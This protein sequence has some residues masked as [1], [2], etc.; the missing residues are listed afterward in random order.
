[1]E[2]F[3]F[4]VAIVVFFWLAIRQRLTSDHVRKLKSEIQEI[5]AQIARISVEKSTETSTT[6]AAEKEQETPVTEAEPTTESAPSALQQAKERSTISPRPSPP[7]AAESP[8]PEEPISPPPLPKAAKSS[9]PEPAVSSTPSPSPP[10]PPEPLPEAPSK[11]EVAAPVE[12]APSS[13]EDSAEHSWRPYLERLKLWPPSGENAEATIAAWWLTRIGLIILIIAAVFFGVRIAEDTPPWLRLVTLAAISAGVAILGAWLERRLAAFGRLISAGGL[14]LGYFTAFAAYGVEATKVIDNPGLGLL[15]Q[16]LAVILTIGWSLWKNDE[17]IATM[18][19]LLGY[20]ACWFSFHHDLDHFVIA[21]LLVLATGAAVLLERKWWLW[22]IAVATAGSWLG[23]LLLGIGEWSRPGGAPS[24]G[25]I[26][27]SFLLLATL[28]EAANAL[29]FSRENSSLEASQAKWLKRLAIANTSLAIGVGWIAI[30]MAFPPKVETSEIDFFYL[31]FAVLI[32]AFSAV[33]FRLRHPVALVE[34]DFLKASGLLALFLV[35]WFDGPTRWLSLAAQSMIMLWTWRRSRLTWI[36]VG[37]AVLFLATLGVI[38]HDA[39]KL[40]ETGGNPVITVE[41]LV[42]LLSL[43]ILSTCLGFRARWNP[44]ATETLDESPER[45]PSFDPRT[46]LGVLAAIPVGIAMLIITL[47]RLEVPNATAGIAFLSLASLALAA[48]AFLARTFPPVL[49]GLTAVVPTYLLFFAPR[50]QEGEAWL[51]A[52]LAILG[53]G[54]AELVFQ[55]WRR[56]WALGN[57]LRLLLQTLGLIALALTLGRSLDEPGTSPLVALLAL[58]GMTAVAGASLVAQGRAFKVDH[59]SHRSESHA[60]MQWLLALVV[61][62]TVTWVGFALL[63]DFA[64][65]ESFVALFGGLLFT[66]AYATRNAAP[67]L[68]G[69]IPLITATI[70]QVIR[71]DHD[72]PFTQHLLA[73]GLAIA[74]CLATAIALKR[75]LTPE[76]YPAA[77]AMDGALH[78]IALFLAHWVLRSHLDTSLVFFGDTLLALVALFAYRRFQFP[79]LAAISFLPLLCALGHFQV[80]LIL[81][82]L[83]GPRLAW[84]IGVIVIG[85][86]LFLGR[87]WFLE[88]TSGP[89]EPTP[90]KRTLFTCHEA[91]GAAAVAAAGSQALPAPWQAA[92]VTVFALGLAA[93]GRWGRLPTSQGWSV[94][95]LLVGIFASFQEL[96]GSTSSTPHAALTATCLVAFGITIHGVI[97][98][99]REP[100]PR[101]AFAWIH[102]L[103]ALGLAFLA[104]SVDRFGVDSLTTVCWGLSAV[105]LFIIGLAVGIRPYRLTGL[106]GLAIAMVRMFLVDIDDPLYRIYAFFAIALVLLGIGYLYHRFRHLIERADLTADRDGEAPPAAESE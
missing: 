105:I 73:A 92:A 33:R 16:S 8:L 13:T 40:P 84:W 89:G 44:V 12:E 3:L 98:S 47:N 59:G 67:A 55:T 22:P 72:S 68:A 50:G 19:V 15:V 24:Y 26:L 37:F 62:I 42:G 91:L 58:G 69:G 20:V 1:M 65:T 104:F 30:R 103:V 90:G 70:G 83:A 61:G 45:L 32:G 34:T 95:P 46:I 81:G 63:K 71:F 87:Q 39:L 54:S 64:Y 4:L 86:W 96:T 17:P 31:S 76:R 77:S 101:R 102:G 66:V 78:G 79:G 11:T 48:P 14:A 56:N 53:I 41:N 88:Q 106:I 57:A 29:V 93:L 97:L 6:P 38:I 10:P 75:S 23:F 60:L 82:D 99:W 9:P 100:Q 43:V 35:A 80:D 25:I 36:E 28:V 51:G 85:A 7:A 94:V 49:A 27:A 21:G 74:V 52:W 5:R 18:A 2:P